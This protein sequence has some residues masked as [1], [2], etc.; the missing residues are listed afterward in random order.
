MF[1]GSNGLGLLPNSQE[2]KD[3]GYMVGSQNLGQGSLGL[4]SKLCQILAWVSS[5]DLPAL[6]A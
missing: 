5:L 2:Q 6:S 3:F 1:Y 4:T